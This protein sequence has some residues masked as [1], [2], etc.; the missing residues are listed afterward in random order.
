MADQILN[1]SL[2]AASAMFVIAIALV[3]LRLLRGP[4]LPDRVIALDLIGTLA[5]GAIGVY[6]VSQ[7]EP[8]YIFVSIVLAL[9]LFVGTV[10]FAYYM[11]RASDR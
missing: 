10:A 9:V 8:I 7:N 3:T 4:S 5:A 2:I 1:G 6:T 11:E